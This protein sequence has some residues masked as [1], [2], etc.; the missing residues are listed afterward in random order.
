MPSVN[1]V[2]PTVLEIKG[3]SDAILGIANPQLELIVGPLGDLAIKA[4]QAWGKAS[5]VPITVESIE[6]LTLVF[7]LSKPDESPKGSVS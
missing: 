6:A 7:T 3:I 1:D 4:L 5:G 2:I